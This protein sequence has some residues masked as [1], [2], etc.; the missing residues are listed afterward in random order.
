ML[1][2]V[3]NPETNY[4]DHSLREVV[5]TLASVINQALK[6]AE[7]PFQIEYDREGVV[8]T[9]V[10]FS[11]AK[12]SSKPEHCILWKDKQVILLGTEAKSVSHSSQMAMPQCFQV[13]GDGALTLRA[14]RLELEDAIVPG[15]ICAG[16]CMTIVG[17]ALLPPHYPYMVALSPP[18]SILEDSHRKQLAR[19]VMS[20]IIIR[21]YIS[22]R[23]FTIEVTTRG[24]LTP[25]ILKTWLSVVFEI[26][27][28]W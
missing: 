8:N 21:I 26:C 7:L 19:H 20:P 18:L 23:G 13:C 6:D 9:V 12:Q 4:T 17:V 15:I 5:I 25:S 24:H 14:R 22:S 11:L 1:Q 2:T 28:F 3:E 16:E 10:K 27:G